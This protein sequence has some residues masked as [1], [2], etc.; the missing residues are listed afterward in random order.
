MHTLLVACC[1]KGLVLRNELSSP[2]LSSCLSGLHFFSQLLLLLLSNE[3]PISGLFTEESCLPTRIEAGKRIETES[4]FRHMQ[5]RRRLEDDRRIYL[6]S[7]SSSCR[8]ISLSVPLATKNDNH[9]AFAGTPFVGSLW[10]WSHGQTARFECPS[11]FPT[12]ITFSRLLAVGCGHE[13]GSGAFGSTRSSLVPELG[14][15][16]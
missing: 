1:I 10:A 15:D 7:L 16:A 4:I 2:M 5:G 13:V 6:R 8:Q 14:R 3:L 11:R 9:S 12:R